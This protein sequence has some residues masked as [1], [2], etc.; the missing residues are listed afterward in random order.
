LCENRLFKSDRQQNYKIMR[1][2]IVEELEG[3][4]EVAWSPIGFKKM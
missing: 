2:F 3:A 1:Y 4:A